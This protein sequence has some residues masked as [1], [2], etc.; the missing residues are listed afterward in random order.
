MEGRATP[1]TCTRCGGNT[2]TSVASCL[3]RQCRNFIV[4]G[5]VAPGDSNPFLFDLRN[6][7]TCTNCHIDYGQWGD[8]GSTFGHGKNR[9]GVLQFS[10]TLLECP[11]CWE[12]K[13]G[14]AHP[15][16]DHFVC[17]DCF[18]RCYYGD[19][20]QSGKPA[21]PYPE[22]EEEYYDTPEAARWK[23]GRFPLL[24]EFEY[25]DELWD[26]LKAQKYEHEE[27]LRACP[28]CRK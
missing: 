28:L 9:E 18:T 23:N 12:L 25:E 21:F 14:V 2:C 11:V 7:W 6:P 1:E 22:V 5:Y 3:G 10:D 15:R 8:P 16:C 20:D 27:Y 13:T 24:A 4:C 19:P 26:T 17:I